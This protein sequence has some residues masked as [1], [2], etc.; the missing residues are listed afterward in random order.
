MSIIK[1]SN[2]N[3]GYPG[4]TVFKDFC[5]ELPQQQLIMLIGPNGSGK[6]SL[7]H[8]LSGLQ[9]PETG[10]VTI[11]DHPLTHYSQNELAK[12]RAFM[13]QQTIT[14]E[15]MTVQELVA[16]GR[17]AYQGFFGLKSREDE[18][19]ITWAMQ[20]CNVTQFAEKQ[21]SALSGGEGQRV[22]LASALAQKAPILMLDEPC[23][24]LDISYQIDLMKLLRELV[25]QEG[26]TVIMST[27]DLNHTAQYGDHL[28]ALKQG[29]LLSHGP[30]S[31]TL[32]D[33][34]VRD[35]FGVRTEFCT[36]NIS[37][38]QFYMFHA[39]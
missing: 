33:P 25:D 18:E 39:A 35:L 17:Y 28:V 22:W 38:K 12:I 21:L 3:M 2:L 23:S 20:M 30:V 26:L 36:S 6:S 19:A 9:Q 8:C 37:G 7:L 1:I 27:H 4:Q 14:P 13:P 29:A 34:L 11:M 31:Q 32:N 15:A 16:C 5:L 10:V 24:Y